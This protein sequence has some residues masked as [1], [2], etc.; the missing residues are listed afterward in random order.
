MDWVT[1][2]VL[3]FDVTPARSM[4]WFPSWDWKVIPLCVKFLLVT[5]ES[6]PTT[7]QP[8]MAVDPPGKLVKPPL[9]T[10]GVSNE[11]FTIKFATAGVAATAARQ[12]VRT[13]KIRIIRTA[14]DGKRIAN[15]T[16]VR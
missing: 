6:T 5:A 10:I 12:I 1:P 3:L 16:N 9:G 8:V 2:L 11:P 15:S 14:L 4:N 13:R 7:V